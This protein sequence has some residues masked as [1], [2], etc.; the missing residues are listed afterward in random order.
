MSLALVASFR[1][2]K[3]N[4]SCLSPMTTLWYQSLQISKGCSGQSLRHS[5]CLRNEVKMPWKS[6]WYHLNSSQAQPLLFPSA[7]PLLK[8]FFTHWSIPKNSLNSPGFLQLSQFALCSSHSPWLTLGWHPAV[9]GVLWHCPGGYPA[10]LLKALWYRVPLNQ[11]FCWDGCVGKAVAAVM[12]HPCIS[13][14]AM[15]IGLT[16]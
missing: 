16:G 8:F 13:W 6:N 2:D 5:F 3:P 14:C 11:Q 12:H 15:L 7:L 10:A 1:Q 9:L 4:Q